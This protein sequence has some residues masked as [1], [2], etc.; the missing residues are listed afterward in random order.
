[1]ESGSG[2]WIRFRIIQP[3]PKN[4]E[5]KFQ[6]RKLPFCSSKIAIYLFLVFMRDLA[7]EEASSPPNEHQVLYFKIFWHIFTFFLVCGLLLPA[8]IRFWIRI[9]SPDPDTETQVNLDPIW[10]RNMENKRKTIRDARKRLSRKYALQMKGR[11]E[12]NINV[13]FLFMYS[14]NYNV[15]SPNSTFTYLWAIYIFPECLFCCS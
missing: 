4:L 2:F 11:W 3:G 10:I 7:T 1:M 8:W 6:L 14:Q 9:P 12:S 15:L 13:R 5:N